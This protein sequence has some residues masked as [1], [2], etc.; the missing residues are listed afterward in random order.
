MIKP[1][2]FILLQLDQVKRYKNFTITLISFSAYPGCEYITRYSSS[3]HFCS[4]QLWERE[5]F[6]NILVESSINLVQ[7][8]SIDFLCLREWKMPRMI[9]L[10]IKPHITSYCQTYS[11]IFLAAQKLSHYILFFSFRSLFCLDFLYRR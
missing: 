4:F 3:R 10:H 1:L 7:S 5:T 2:D 6:H 11:L 9:N 8:R